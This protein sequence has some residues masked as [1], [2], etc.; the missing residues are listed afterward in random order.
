[1]ASSFVILRIGDFASFTVFIIVVQGFFFV[2]QI[3]VK[4]K[5][6]SW[7]N[8]EDLPEKEFKKC[9]DYMIFSFFK[10]GFFFSCVEE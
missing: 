9:G 8:G 7:F 5:N 2:N 4:L 10:E 3:T 1:M 6:Q